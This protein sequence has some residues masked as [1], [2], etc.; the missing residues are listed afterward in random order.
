MNPSVYVRRANRW[1]DSFN[2]LRGLKMPQV[3]AWLEAGERGEYANLQ[4]LYRVVE[5]RDAVLRALVRRR[6]SALLKLDWDI[7]VVSELPKGS[8]DAQAE[9]QQ[10]A[11]RAAYDRIDN[12]REAIAFL[13]LAEFR[14]YS[15]LERHFTPQ[16]ETFHLET[17]PQWHWVRDGINGVW[18]YNAESAA[19]NHGESIDPVNFLIRE[20]EDPI[21][22]IAVICFLR[23]NLSQKDWDGF[24][25]TYGIPPL[26]VEGP[27]NAGDKDGEYQTIAEEVVSNGRGYLPNG[28]KVQTVETGGR[29]NNPFRDHLRYQDEQIVMAGTGGLLTML[30]DPTGLGSGQSESHQETFDEIA[31][32]EAAIISELFQEQF[33]KPILDEKFQGQPILAYFEIAAK[34]ET[35]IAS[36]ADHAVKFSQAGFSMDAEELSEKSG[37]KL[38]PKPS[39][40]S[41]FEGVPPISNRAR[42]P[43][44]VASARA[45]LAR[46]Q[47]RVLLPLRQRLAE[48]E[49]MTDESAQK[50]ALVALRNDLPALLK[51]MNADPRTAR[52]IEN[53]LAASLFNGLAEAAKP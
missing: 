35:D 12:L 2:P 10:V 44:L 19:T 25:E 20:V 30:N 27:P 53:T 6:R 23:K 37:Y 28:A 36:L 31:Q 32:A 11:L 40:P 41:P 43:Q 33:D 13:A 15:H 49:A 45:E 50:E 21:D 38:T 22:E 17:V 34:D 26:F 1:R 5:K 4:W 29:G 7:K 47:A 39:A 18:Q 42:N 8:T 51:K 46:A 9:A 48:I 14:G 3:V 24:V 52:I 16:G